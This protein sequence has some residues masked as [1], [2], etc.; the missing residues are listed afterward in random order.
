[1]KLNYVKKIIREQVEEILNETHRIYA[2]FSD[3]NMRDKAI[4]NIGEIPTSIRE[5][6]IVYTYKTP[7]EGEELKE[8]IENNGGLV[9]MGAKDYDAYKKEVLKQKEERERALER[10]L[11]K[12][13][14]F[15]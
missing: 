1:M 3:E 11:E 8:K 5:K 13:M 4:E 15:K 7:E 6:N 10:T 14:Y 9:I 12:K 2:K